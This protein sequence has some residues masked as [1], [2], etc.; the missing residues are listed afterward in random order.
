MARMARMR[1][2]LLAGLMLA[3]AGCGGGSGGSGN[4][5][6]S[7]LGFD[8]A[9]TA[10]LQKAIASLSQTS[11]PSQLSAL[12]TAAGTRYPTACRIHLG[13]KPNHFELFAYWKPYLEEGQAA[14]YSW[15]TASIAPNPS[16]DSV[17]VTHS[18]A[19]VST[20]VAIDELRENLPADYFST[21][22]ARCQVATDGTV[23]VAQPPATTTATG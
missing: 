15:L 18:N 7:G 2:I 17:A 3:L 6:G 13:V 16:A 19:R 20:A 10:T 21:P 23:S 8:A 1:P 22:Y 14:Y 5:T 9:D 4:T 12:T 11:I